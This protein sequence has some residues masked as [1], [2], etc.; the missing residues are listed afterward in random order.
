[1]ESSAQYQWLR[2]LGTCVMNTKRRPICCSVQTCFVSFSPHIWLSRSIDVLTVGLDRWSGFDSLPTCHQQMVN[3]IGQC[4][5]SAEGRV[6]Y[7]YRID[8]PGVDYILLACFMVQNISS[9]FK[10]F[11]NKLLA[12]AHFSTLVI[13]VAHESALQ[14]GVISYVL[15]AYLPV[16]RHMVYDN[17][18]VFGNDYSIC[19]ILCL[20][21]PKSTRLLIEQRVTG[22]YGFHKVNWTAT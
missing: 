11:K 5:S 14:A 3:V 12:T 15:S 21:M 6:S 2:Y 10:E 19:F 16:Y 7:H 1:M 13:S 17:C 18:A 9:D 22:T 8:S 20:R 4:N